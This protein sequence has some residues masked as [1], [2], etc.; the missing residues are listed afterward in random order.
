MTDKPGDS[1]DRFKWWRDLSP[2]VVAL[3]GVVATAITVAAFLGPSLTEP[4]A[5]PSPTPSDQRDGGAQLVASVTSQPGPLPDETQRSSG[6]FSTLQLPDGTTGL[7]WEVEGAPGITF[8]VLENV[9]LGF[10]R[11]RLLDIGN[12]A[13]TSLESSARLYIANPT[14][15]SQPF[16]V[17]VF[18]VLGS[19]AP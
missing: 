13:E 5:S 8:D 7:R 9:E 11:P 6:D 15:A 12:G 14:N 17:R 18:A 2:L 1:N 10:D 3:T 19:D 4:T 16:E